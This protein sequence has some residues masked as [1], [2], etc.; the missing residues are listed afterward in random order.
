MDRSTL[1]VRRQDVKVEILRIKNTLIVLALFDPLNNQHLGQLT[2]NHG[3]QRR[4]QLE[5]Q[6]CEW[7]DD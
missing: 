6:Y 4:H 2:F 1:P 7:A 3:H 5:E